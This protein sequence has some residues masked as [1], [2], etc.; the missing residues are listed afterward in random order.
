MSLKNILTEST[1]SGDEV[2]LT[3]DEF[4]QIANEAFVS[5][6]A[7]IRLPK[8]M[9][10][11]KMFEEIVDAFFHLHS[12]G[13]LDELRS[14]WDAREYNGDP[15]LMAYGFLSWVEEKFNDMFRGVETTAMIARLISLD[16]PNELNA[17]DLGRH[18]TIPVKR[19]FDEDFILSIE[20]SSEDR[21]FGD[22]DSLYVIVGELDPRHLNFPFD[23]NF[24]FNDENEVNLNG[25]H[26]N[27]FKWLAVCRYN[28]VDSHNPKNSKILKQLI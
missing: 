15:E 18:W 13:E 11:D 14:S 16:N 20:G 3:P 5:G 4:R 7:D 1:E 17:E 23:T 21:D 10:R 6:F 26:G 19:V 25:F 12:L 2:T 28:D 22:E 27:L 8:F 9:D 24:Y